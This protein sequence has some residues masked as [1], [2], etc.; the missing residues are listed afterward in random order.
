[1][2]WK[3]S[4]NQTQEVK[5]KEAELEIYKL[6]LIGYNQLVLE[7]DKAAYQEALSKLPKSKT[8]LLKLK[9]GVEVT[10][11]ENVTLE[12]VPHGQ[13]INQYAISFY[14]G[15]TPI[16]HRLHTEES[17]LL[18]LRLDLNL[19]ISDVDSL[20]ISQRYPE[21]YIIQ[22]KI[23]LDYIIRHNQLITADDGFTYQGAEILG[24]KEITSNKE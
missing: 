6:A 3:K 14:N 2:F 11:T 5:F 17:R 24:F 15:F 23:D 7:K 18:Q 19:S 21:Q 10:L 13:L 20:K 16:Y 22:G 8:F 1:M 12:V 4:K 9:N